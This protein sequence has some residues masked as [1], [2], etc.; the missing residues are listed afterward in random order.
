M[1][2][3]LHAPQ[4]VNFRITFCIGGGRLYLNSILCHVCG[5]C[6]APHYVSQIFLH[7]I[8][9]AYLVFF[10]TTIVVNVVFQINHCISFTLIVFA[11]AGVSLV[12]TC[13][14]I[15]CISMTNKS[16]MTFLFCQ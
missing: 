6:F 10:K 16:V 1:G 7:L 8:L 12:Y 15:S 9:V 2:G 13:T 4:Y 14:Y 3:G 5:W 11:G